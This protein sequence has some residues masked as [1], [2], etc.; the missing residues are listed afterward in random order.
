MECPK[1][2]MNPVLFA[3]PMEITLNEGWMLCEADGMLDHICDVSGL[4]G[5]STA[6][7]TGFKSE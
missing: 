5:R 2:R 4:L 7:R 1:G 6:E 3:Y